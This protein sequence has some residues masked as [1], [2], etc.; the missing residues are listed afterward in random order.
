LPKPPSVCF[1]PPIELAIRKA[2][3]AAPPIISIS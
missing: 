2:P 1:T 3:I